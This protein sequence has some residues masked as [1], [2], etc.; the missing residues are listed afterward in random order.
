[1]YHVLAVAI[2]LIAALALIAG[3]IRALFAPTR[4]T[5][6]FGTALEL[7]S[8]SESEIPF[9]LEAKPM[10]ADAAPAISKG[11]WKLI[12]CGPT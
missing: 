4:A 1:M 9:R 6:S 11:A 7:G 10:L 2:C 12:C 3:A 5:S 8:V